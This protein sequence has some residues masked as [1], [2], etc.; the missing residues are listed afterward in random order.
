MRRNVAE[1]PMHQVGANH[2]RSARLT[3]GTGSRVGMGMGMGRRAGEMGRTP[4]QSVAAL[5]RRCG[6]ASHNRIPT[7]A[8]IATGWTP[9]NTPHHAVYPVAC[10]LTLQCSLTDIVQVAPSSSTGRSDDGSCFTASSQGDVRSSP[11][12]YPAVRSLPKL[13]LA[14]RPEAEYLIV[15]LLVRP[16]G[17]QAQS[18]VIA[19]RSP[20]FSRYSRPILQLWTAS[21]H[22]A[23]SPLPSCKPL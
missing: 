22:E 1:H 3:S 16:V 20:A 2:A 11:M 8:S 21:Y 6:E 7:L 12:A 4:D 18:L 14:L 5:D 13:P 17:H 10:L 23:G 9:W 19:L 15:G